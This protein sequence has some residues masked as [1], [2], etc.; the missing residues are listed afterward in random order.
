MLW[1]ISRNSHAEIV[2]LLQAEIAELKAERK[3]TLDYILQQSAGRGLFTEVTRPV[4][5]Q[6]ATPAGYFGRP[7]NEDTGELTAR[8][9][10]AVVRQLQER[11]NRE[12]DLLTEAQRVILH[13]VR[14]GQQA[15]Q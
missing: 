3:Q 10:R 13:T 11:V 4:P 2:A 7:T 14:E 5:L 8:H 9:P 6:E 1:F 15:A 12:A